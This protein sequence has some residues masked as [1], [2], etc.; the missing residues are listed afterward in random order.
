MMHLDILELQ[1]HEPLHAVT[2]MCMLQG[3]AAPADGAK[4]GRLQ[5]PKP[6]SLGVVR[7]PATHMSYLELQPQLPVQS[8]EHTLVLQ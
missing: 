3:S 5:M 7:P 8:S 4:V 1:P 2:Q 6:A